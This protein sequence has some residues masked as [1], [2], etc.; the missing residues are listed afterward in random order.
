MTK[1]SGLFLPGRMK[2]MDEKTYVE[3]PCNYCKGSGKA[4]GGECQVCHGKASFMVKEPPMKCQFC[5]GNGFMMPGSPC[6]TCKGTGW[7]GVKKN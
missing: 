2:I 5:K 6:R 4:D 1:M 7:M 3:Q